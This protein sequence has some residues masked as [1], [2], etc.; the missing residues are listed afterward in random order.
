MDISQHEET[1]SLVKKLVLD[2]HFKSIDSHTYLVAMLD[3]H[4]YFQNV[5]RYTYGS[6]YLC[7]FLTLMA[8]ILFSMPWIFFLNQY[9]HT[10]H[11]L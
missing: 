8:G 5:G 2:G 4:A 11:P 6:K 1:M 10:P 9:E 3:I 7:A